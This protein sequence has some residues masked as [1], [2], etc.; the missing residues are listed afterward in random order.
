M[1]LVII[2]H[3]PHYWKGGTLAGWGSTILEIDHLATMFEAIIHVAPVYEEPAPE[4]SLPYRAKNIE[5]RSVHPAGGDGLLKKIGILWAWLSYTGILLREMKKADVVHVRC[6]ANI[7]LL[8]I[9]LLA[10]VRRPK[11]RWAKYAGNWK[12]EGK[13]P[14]SYAFQRWFLRQGLHKGIV[15]VNGKWPGQERHVY[16]FLNPSLI[17]SEV[18]K[19]RISAQA[20]VIELPLCLLFVGRLETAKGAGRVLE[21][22]KKVKEYG[23][24]FD[25]HMVGD[26]PERPLFEEWTH[27]NG[28]SNSVVFHGWLPRPSLGEYY[29]K[30][31]FLVFPSSASEGWPKV[32]SE[33]M[34]YGAVPIAGAVSGIPQIL[35]ETGGGATLRPDDVDG[36]VNA[37]SGFLNNPSKWKAFS[38]AGIDSACK[39]TYESY[40][41]SVREMFDKTWNLKL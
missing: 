16:S 3:T 13:D 14:W 5:I 32:L 9:I 34:A 23:I 7:S 31:H 4:S 35:S 28:L 37:I 11:F 12:P 2:S 20:K 1:K 22:V 36:F 24:P 6:P 29:A 17:Q 30:A 40:L 10:I 8:S 33:A 15:T 21:I 25:L 41:I 38:L 27:K 26:G 18:E 39:F 19:I